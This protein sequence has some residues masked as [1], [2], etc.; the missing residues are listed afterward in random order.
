MNI[1]LVAILDEIVIAIAVGGALYT[2]RHFWS[3]I[4]SAWYYVLSRL[5][6]SEEQQKRE[7]KI[8]DY[9]IK[10]ALQIE[11]YIDRCVDIANIEV[12]YHSKRDVIEM[13]RPVEICPDYVLNSHMD[14][15]LVSCI[16]SLKRKTEKT[17]SS[18]IGVSITRPMQSDIAFFEGVRLE[19]AQFGLESCGIL[20]R[21]KKIYKL[22]HARKGDEEPEIVLQKRI[23]KLKRRNDSNG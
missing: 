2:I 18:V 5:Q 1:N 3:K 17:F 16:R 6:P 21:W 4:K 7:E 19:F 23:K 11:E 10:A 22:P 15:E 8:K 14:Y 9:A 12:H 20:K 13:F